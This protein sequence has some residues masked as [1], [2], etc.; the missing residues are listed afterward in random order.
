[1]R[2]AI[3]TRA[4]MPVNKWVGNAHML[5]E[6]S[7]EHF[8]FGREFMGSLQKASNL[9]VEFV[10]APYELLPFIDME[11][12]GWPVLPIHRQLVPPWKK[13]AGFEKGSQLDQ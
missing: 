13:A 8:Q 2:R 12:L 1:M 4:R 9:D 5:E 7:L 6:T 3:E 10:T 11:R